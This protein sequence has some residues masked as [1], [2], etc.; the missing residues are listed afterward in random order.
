MTRALVISTL[1]RL[2]L[3]AIWIWAGIA[4]AVDPLATLRSVR[5]YELLPEQAAQLVAFGLPFFEIGLGGLLLAGVAVR[6]LALVSLGLLAVFMLAVGSAWAR[7]LNIDCGCF[8]AGGVR[9]AYLQEL[10]RDL[11]FGLPAAWLA[12]RPASRFA[13]GSPA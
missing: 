13:L 6:P 8:G 10:L 4:K 1:C 2:A 5:A 9:G 7:G 3:G 11:G 12:L